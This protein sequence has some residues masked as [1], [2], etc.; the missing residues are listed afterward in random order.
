M[1]TELSD[2]FDGTWNKI[3]IKPL[4]IAIATT[5]NDS[6][7]IRK[8]RGYMRRILVEM[9]RSRTISTRVNHLQIELTFGVPY[10]DTSSV[11]FR[12]NQ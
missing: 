5:Q 8:C 6:I 9:K 3:S 10:S 2:A 11:V 1:S 7:S 4:S 12:L